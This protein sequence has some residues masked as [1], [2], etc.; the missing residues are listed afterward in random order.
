MAVTIGP[1]IVG[2][3]A[4]SG[5]DINP[6]KRAAD[7]SEGLNK[8]IPLFEVNK[9]NL[10]SALIKVLEAGVSI[11]FIYDQ[12][13]QPISLKI[14]DASINQI[15][16]AIIAKA[17]GYEWSISSGVIHVQPKKIAVESPLGYLQKTISGFSCQEYDVTMCINLL[18]RHAQLSG[19]PVY[20]IDISSGA[21]AITADEIAEDARISIKI[22]QPLRLIDI[23]DSIIS[24][25]PPGHWQ[26][27]PV[28]KG[29]LIAFVGGTSHGHTEMS[30]KAKRLE[31]ELKR[32]GGKTVWKKGNPII[33]K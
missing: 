22:E 8:I 16:D 28:R 11:G 21:L 26:A 9:A 30:R 25:N 3:P 19:L 7:G 6:K 17:P 24:Q 14:K 12:L 5:A 29:Q 33:P 1:H 2:I 32:R 18:A 31:A 4:A 10:Q 20:F 27:H 13:P 15:L 23:L